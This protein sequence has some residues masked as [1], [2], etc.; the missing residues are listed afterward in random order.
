MRNCSTGWFRIGTDEMFIVQNLKAHKAIGMRSIVL[1]TLLFAQSNLW[2]QSANTSMSNAAEAGKKM[3]NPL[4]PKTQLNFSYNYNQKIGTN[5]GSQQN[6]FAF[7][8]II[9]ISLN[10]DL[11]LLLNPLLTFNRNLNAPEVT[12]QF[13]PV[14]FGAFFAPRLQGDWFVGAGP[15]LQA[16]ANNA[17]NGSRQTGLGFTAGAFYTPRNWVLGATM[18]NAWGI[19]SDMS[20]GSA[21]VFYLQPLISYTM[22][23]G[24]NLNLESAWTY[25]HNAKNGNNQITL[26][27]G[28]TIKIG[29]MSW[30]FQIGPTYT[31]P[32]SPSSQKGWGAFFSLTTAIDN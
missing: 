6:E 22:N 18:Y 17:V 25:N 32:S 10:A 28:K 3:Q 27:G 14:Q 20:G 11:Q 26:S 7:E 30:Q 9:P 16:P 8:P 31:A 21:N 4:Y 15:Y 2:A 1:V 23:N 19:G 12:N 13:Q 24:W 29:R 5:N